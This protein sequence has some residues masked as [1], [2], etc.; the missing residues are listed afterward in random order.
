MIFV[1]QTELFRPGERR[2]AARR[3]RD[4]SGETLAADD[5]RQRGTDEA[6]ANERDAFEKRF[7][8]HDFRNSASAA[9]TPRF[10][11]SV[12]IVMRSALGKP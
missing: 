10:A 9:T 5:M 6:N 11:S 2:G 1:A 12:P 8:H 4:R 3:D 7:G